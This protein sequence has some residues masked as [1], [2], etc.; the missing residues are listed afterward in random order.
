MDV[1]IGCTHDF[2]KYDVRIN[3]K[4]GSHAS[5]P[6]EIFYDGEWGSICIDK[7]DVQDA[8]V[9]CRQLSFHWVE[10]RGWEHDLGSL[11]GKKWLNEV[12]CVGTET[13]LDTCPGASG[14]FYHHSCSTTASVECGWIS[15]YTEARALLL[16]GLGDEN[17]AFE[18]TAYLQISPA[19]RVAICDHS[20]NMKSADAFCRQLGKHSALRV[21]TGSYY[22]RHPAFN[23]IFPVRKWNMAF[24]CT[25]QE[26]SLIDCV[27][28]VK[29]QSECPDGR[30]AGVV[31]LEREAPQGF[32]IK[33]V[34]GATAS[35]GRVE[36]CYG[37]TCG[38]LG[39]DVNLEN[40]ASFGDVVCRELNQGYAVEVTSDGRFG[41]GQNLIKMNKIWCAGSEES[42]A[43]CGPHIQWLNST[44]PALKDEHT[45]V[46]CSG[47]IAAARSPIRFSQLNERG[48]IVEIFHQGRFGTICSKGWT[49]GNAQVVCRE[50]GFGPPTD[51]Q[52][53][54]DGYGGPI[55]L[56]DIR[57]TG[58]EESLDRCQRSEWSAHTCD[59]SM[60]VSVL[61]QQGIG[62][63][64]Y[65]SSTAQKGVSKA[66]PKVFLP[67]LYK[68]HHD[69]EDF[70]KEFR[71]RA[72][73]RGERVTS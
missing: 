43:Q 54:L 42:L 46:R 73:D 38:S 5:G 30:D 59:H 51:A 6:V 41:P 60:D 4:L 44:D 70:P 64:P 8:F 16:D 7:W 12:E 58:A 11:T 57:C 69:L 21:T 34:G 52:L 29:P 66:I 39:K 1:Y 2:D 55:F 62:I 14:E 23:G 56:Q 37:G 48:G 71:E 32:A 15:G 47:P 50:L 72:R 27:T 61:C 10:E 36:V 20:W 49:M 3:P 68:I 40:L 17:I 35:E 9:A 25:G 65:G 13:S 63:Y 26:S 33:L 28:H 19:E 24:E 53:G 22:G 67:N 31:C 18:G 45:G